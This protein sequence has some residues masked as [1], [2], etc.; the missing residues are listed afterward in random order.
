VHNEVLNLPKELDSYKHPVA[1]DLDGPFILKP[2]FKFV[3]WNLANEEA[4]TAR[5]GTLRNQICIYQSR[6]KTKLWN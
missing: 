3:T 6:D 4:N 2:S 5:F 1:M